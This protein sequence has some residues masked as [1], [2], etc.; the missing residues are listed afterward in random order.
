MNTHLIIT[1]IIWSIV[2]FGAWYIFK[3]EKGEIK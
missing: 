1:L 2:V 3:L